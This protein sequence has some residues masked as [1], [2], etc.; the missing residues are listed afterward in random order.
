MSCYL[1]CMVITKAQFT[2][3]CGYR[4]ISREVIFKYYS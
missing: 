3:N 1:G 2:V 4:D